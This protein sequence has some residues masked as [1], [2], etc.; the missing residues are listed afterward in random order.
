[1]KRRLGLMITFLFLMGLA[2]AATSF[3][4]LVRNK[5]IL[6]NPMFISRE[7]DTIGVDISHYQGTVD[8]DAIADQNIK[9]AYIKAT[10]G[11]SYTD[12]HFREN[13]QN[14][15][16]DGIK[17]QMSFGAYHFFSFESSG[18]A[19]AENY[20]TIVGDLSGF[21]VPAVDV[22]LYGKYR[23]TMPEKAQIVKE[24]KALLQKLEAKY[25]TKPMIYSEIDVYKRYLSDDFSSY[26]LWLRSVYYPIDWEFHDDWTLWQY[27]DRG[28]LDGYTDEKYIDLNKLNPRKSLTDF[29]I[30]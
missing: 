25:L 12:E 7:K 20:I 6:L 9:F 13:W 21:L 11:S 8:F 28:E 14:I 3:F 10:E 1:M 15:K 29:V 17:S 16:T 26:P 4:F 23:E 27:T 24:L 18:Q 30:K 22:E 5:Q 19:Q 2:V